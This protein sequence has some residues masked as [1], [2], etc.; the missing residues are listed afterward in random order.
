ME[1]GINNIEDFNLAYRTCVGVLT[2]KKGDKDL[3]FVDHLDNSKYLRGYSPG[4]SDWIPA[5]HRLEDVDVDFSMPE[6][7]LVNH[8]KA[9]INVMRRAYKQYRR[10][11][12]WKNQVVSHSVVEPMVYDHMIG[13]GIGTDMKVVQNIFDPIYYSV[14]DALNLI[15][16]KDRP[17][18][19][20]TNRYYISLS[21]DLPYIYLGF[22][23]GNVIGR[24]NETNA[25]CTIFKSAE[26]L[27]EDLVNYVE[28]R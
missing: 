26:P 25:R 22:G 1:L 17:T 21:S 13:G 16:S 8:E 2:D 6:L 7:G 11:F 10:G 24:V 20:I 3:F 5:K 19:A 23:S 4:D 27:I 14:Q 12:T 18:V 9:V 28:I 15:Q